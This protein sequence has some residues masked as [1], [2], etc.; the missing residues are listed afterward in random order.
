MEEVVKQAFLHVDVIGPHVQ[1]GHYDLIGSDGRIILPMLWES[2]IKPGEIIEMR[3]WPMEKP[4]RPPPP[5]PPPSQPPGWPLGQQ[6][7]TQQQAWNGDRSRNQSRQPTNPI[8]P[9]Q[10]ESLPKIRLSGPPRRTDGQNPASFLSPGNESMSVGQHWKPSS[11]APPYPSNPHP[12]QPSLNPPLDPFSPIPTASTMERNRRRA[13]EKRRRA[14]VPS[15]S[16]QSSSASES[17]DDGDNESTAETA[18]IPVKSRK[19]DKPEE[20]T[21]KPEKKKEN[22]VTRFGLWLSK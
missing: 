15:E 12:N 10:A 1:E 4:P 18:S 22:I 16:S 5:P 19:I 2:V 11:P 8:Q 3:M 14:P 9:P 17:S 20:E 21:E 7:P 13:Q 6:Y